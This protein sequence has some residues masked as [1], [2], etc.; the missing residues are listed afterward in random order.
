MKEYTLIV[1]SVV[2]EIFAKTSIYLKKQHLFWKVGCKM[3]QVC[4]TFSVSIKH[5]KL[6]AM[7]KSWD[8]IFHTVINAQIPIY[9]N[10]TSLHAMISF[11]N[12]KFMKTVLK[13]I[14]HNSRSE[15]FGL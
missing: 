1:K 11:P 4:V 9:Q 15:H 3:A 6:D 2:E 8:F 13:T 14:H 5:E 10:L 12:N 7:P